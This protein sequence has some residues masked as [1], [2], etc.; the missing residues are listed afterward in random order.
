M[1][2][3]KSLRNKKI[4]FKLRQFYEPRWCRYLL[5]VC[6]SLLPRT[7]L[8]WISFFS[9]LFLKKTKQKFGNLQALRRKA[10]WTREKEKD[11]SKQIRWFYRNGRRKRKKLFVVFLWDVVESGRNLDKREKLLTFLPLINIIHWSFL[12]SLQT[13]CVSINLK[14]HTSAPLALRSIVFE[15]STNHLFSSYLTVSIDKFKVLSSNLFSVSTWFHQKFCSV[16]W[17][18]F[19]I[20]PTADI[21]IQSKYRLCDLF[22]VF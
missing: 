12:T 17:R 16:A 2:I 3:Q 4:L 22:L 7:F 9:S 1:K 6:S 15:L 18:W 19:A 20:H 11:L 10:V 13:I 21:I 8:M 14:V 5:R